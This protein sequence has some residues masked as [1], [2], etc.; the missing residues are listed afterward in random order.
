MQHAP[1]TRR[2]DPRLEQYIRSLPKADL[3]LHLTGCARLDTIRSLV[4]KYANDLDA[5][6]GALEASVTFA[7]PAQSYASS[8]S[9]WRLVLNRLTYHPGVL[10]LIAS[11]LAED[12]AVDGVVYAEVRVSPR[13]L[14]MN[15]TLTETLAALEVVRKSALRRLGVDMRWILGFTREFFVQSDL[16]T[17]LRVADAYLEAAEPYRSD[18]IVGF[19][20]WGNETLAPPG[21]FAPVFEVIRH[22]GYPLTIHAGEIA[23]PTDIE[24][25]VGDLRAVRVGHALSAPK[26]QR[27]LAK[28]RDS[29]VLVETCLTSNWVT[30]AFRRLEDHPL[31]MMAA[32]GLAVTLGTDNRLVDRTTLSHEYAVALRLGLI[33]PSRLHPMMMLAPAFAFC[34]QAERDLLLSHLLKPGESSSVETRIAALLSAEEDL[35]QTKG[36]RLPLDA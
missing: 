26:S 22:A 29:G 23:T 9:P 17:Q 10:P 28:I 19:D 4:A 25:A 3:H 2:S 32:E 1:A 14:Y 21:R 11:E 18:G 30:G 33:A 35:S 6:G 27:V 15:G 16:K 34:S 8:F 20:L 36:P 5:Y 7:N 12:L 31:R 13:L 24:E